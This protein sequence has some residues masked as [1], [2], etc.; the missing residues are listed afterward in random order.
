[1]IN[2][3]NSA[4]VEKIENLLD[5]VYVELSE[6]SEQNFTEKFTSATNKMNSV[7]EI[8][9]Q[10]SIKSNNFKPSKKIIQ[11]AKLISEKYDNHIK[12]W[13][14]KLKMVKKEIELTQNQKKITIYNR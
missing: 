5:E 11:M 10:K 6:L 9:P 2:K 3:P 4:I 7:R 8:I 14:E 13:A 12:D 1:M